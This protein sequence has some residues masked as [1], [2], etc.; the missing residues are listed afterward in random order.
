ME[1]TDIFNNLLERQ[2]LLEVG[3]DEVE[4]LLPAGEDES[5]RTH[6]AIGT[7]NLNGCTCFVVLGRGKR[8]GIVMA[9]AGPTVLPEHGGS[10]SGESA[11]VAK[12]RGITRGNKHFM[13]LFRRVALEVHL[14]EKRGMLLRA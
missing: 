1:P 10:S 13:D 9:H 12:E 4:V 14:S 6:E 3:M 2:A 8:R 7:Q 5:I 11:R